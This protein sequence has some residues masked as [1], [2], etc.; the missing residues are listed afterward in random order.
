MKISLFSFQT[1]FCWSPDQSISMVSGETTLA[2]WFT[3][4]PPSPG[5]CCRNTQWQGSGMW[6]VWM[7]SGCYALFK[8]LNHQGMIRLFDV[9][10]TRSLGTEEGERA[11]PEGNHP[12]EPQWDRERWE[13][14]SLRAGTEQREMKGAGW[15]RGQ[16]WLWGRTRSRRVRCLKMQGK[17]LVSSFIKTHSCW[18]LGGA[19]RRQCR[20][21]IWVASGDS[22]F[23]R[24]SPWPL[25]KLMSIYF[26]S[27]ECHFQPSPPQIWKK[28]FLM[29]QF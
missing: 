21:Q 4:Q 3:P 18:G 5:N 6:A 26:E 17:H 22:G 13:N 7:Y 1:E 2:T 24:A 10:W 14:L 20:L 25:L 23:K 12:S 11:P 28:T 27:G 15:A 19:G 9:H 8:D 29:V 16:L